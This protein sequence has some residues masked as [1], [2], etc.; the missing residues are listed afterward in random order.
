[1]S[2]AG[3]YRRNRSDFRKILLYYFFIFVFVVAFTGF[4]CSPPS[5]AGVERVLFS[6]PLEKFTFCGFVDV[7]VEDVFFSAALLFGSCSIILVLYGVLAEL[8]V[9]TGDV[10]GAELAMLTQNR[11]GTFFS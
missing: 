8:L 6:V 4:G 1:M 11:T 3:K 7:G 5:V 10:S 2:T 9:S